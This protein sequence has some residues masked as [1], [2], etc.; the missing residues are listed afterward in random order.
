MNNSEYADNLIASEQNGIEASSLFQGSFMDLNM[1]TPTSPS[2]MTSTSMDTLLMPSV[3]GLNGNLNG[4]LSS[5]SPFGPQIDLN[6]PLVLGAALQNPA[7]AAMYFGLQQL[8]QQATQYSTILKPTEVTSTQTVYATKTISFYDGRQTRTRTITEPGSVT[9]KIL[10]TTTQ[11]LQP[12]VNPQILVQQAQ[13]QR[14]FASQLLQSPQQ[15]NSN[16]NNNQGNLQSLIPNLFVPPPSGQNPFNNPSLPSHLNN[17]QSSLQNAFLQQQQQ[18]QQQ[19]Q[20]LLQQSSNNN[21]NLQNL[22]PQI[23]PSVVTESVT[24][25]TTATSTSTKVYTLIYNAFSTKYRTVTSSSL[26]PTTVT[27]VITKTMT[28]AATA[29]SFNFFG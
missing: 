11:E 27:Q 25:V 20:N 29:A 15:L 9:T 14:A 3:N 18:Q 10:Q 6:N 21:N 12:V 19:N 28:P 4:L 24:S 17:L 16:N 26:F 5:S 23:K 2:V 13:L 8:S 1:I 7:L 22:L